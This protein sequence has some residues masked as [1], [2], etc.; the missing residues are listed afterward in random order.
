MS[1]DL[2]THSLVSDGTQPPA[3]VVAAAARAGL[4][5]IA[6][7]DHDTT[8]GWDEAIAAAQQHGLLL[9]P[10]MEITTKTSNGI[11]VHML[12]YLHDPEHAGLVAAIA[13]AREGRV[14]RAKRICAL[15]AEDFPITWDSV[16][17]HV[18]PDATIGRPHLA[19]AL[20]AAGVV[21]TRSE[22]FQ[23]YLHSR[24]RYYVPQDNISP[25][26][27]IRLVLEAGGIPVLAHGMASSRGRTVSVDQLEEMIEAGLAG[28]EVWHR[29][30][31]DQGRELLLDLARRHDLLTTGSSDY[32]GDGKPNPIGE[33]T[34]D[35][36]T[37]AHILERATGSPA[38]GEFRAA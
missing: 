23:K 18:G 33:N 7:T 19:D 10:G 37:V 9:L 28:V 38:Y 24:S 6:L 8:A 35:A 17:E 32:H 15:L 2:H 36:A 26:A 11:S 20:V 22:A 21:G 16:V 12:S 29:D 5:G 25:T 4:E 27:A 13:E 3:D 31:P 34:T 14:E 1:F 30:N